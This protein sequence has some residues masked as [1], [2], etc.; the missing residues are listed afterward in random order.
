MA[1]RAPS[2]VDA[3]VSTLRPRLAR[4]FSL[5]TAVILTAPLP[6]GALAFAADAQRFYLSVELGSGGWILLGWAWLLG[7]PVLTAAATVATALETPRPALLRVEDGALVVRRRKRE[8]RHPADS[9]LAGLLTRHGIELH[10]ADGRVLR[11]EM[12]FAD[13]EATLEALALGPEHRRATLALGAEG[14]RLAA[15]CIALP[16]GLVIVPF[17][18]R[19]L[20]ALIPG[21]PDLVPG[22]LIFCVP[23]LLPWLARH[24]TAPADL[25]IGTD[26][27]VLRRGGRPRHIPLESILSAEAAHGD[28]VLVL[29]PRAGGAKR[30]ILRLPAGNADRAWGAAERILVAKRIAAQPGAAPIPELD[31]AGRPLPAWREALSRLRRGEGEYRRAQVR[32]EDLLAVLQDGQAPAKLRIGA[33]LALCEGA[34]ATEART[35]VRIAAGTCADEELRAALEAAAEEEIA[36]GAIRRVVERKGPQ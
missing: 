5:L 8:E 16:V 35:K 19:F 33:A 26:G 20:E 4:L 12:P 34:A 21:L 1:M 31:P 9:V 7:V 14:R 13:A 32:E 25:V 22:I 23:F 28:L 2:A 29:A 17:L 36:E 30:E 3:V 10:L 24:L 15:G 27:L 11:I 6:L 18:G